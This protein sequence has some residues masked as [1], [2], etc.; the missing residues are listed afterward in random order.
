MHAIDQIGV[1]QFSRVSRLYRCEVKRGQAWV[2]A[3]DL[4][5][6]ADPG[7][8][9]GCH[10]WHLQREAVIILQHG[11]GSEKGLPANMCCQQVLRH[12]INPRVRTS[13]R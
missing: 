7:H 9:G 6:R 12:E 5:S 11:K 10:H 1:G 8:V 13:V 2:H 4:G 3:H